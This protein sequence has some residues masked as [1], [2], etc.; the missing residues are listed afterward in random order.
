MPERDDFSDLPGLARFGEALDAAARRAPPVDGGP[1]A[2]LAARRRARARDRARRRGDGGGDGRRA[3]RHGHLR[4]RRPHPAGRPDLAGQHERADRAALRRPRRRTAV[5]AAPDAQPDRPDLH[6]RRPGAR[7]RLRDRRRGPR[8]PPDP[9][10]GRRLVRARPAARQPDR[11]R[12]DDPRDALDRLRRRR[13]HHPAGRADRRGRAAHAVARRA[14]HVRRRAA[15]LSGGHRRP[16]R[17]DGR[18]RPRHRGARSAPGPASC[19]ISPAPPRG[20]CCA[21]SSARASTA[22]G[23][24]TRAARVDRFNSSTDPNGG[25]SS[26]PT[27]CIARRGGFAWAARALRVR[28]R[29]ARSARLRSLA[30]HG[31]RPAHD[32]AR[33]RAGLGPRHAGDGDRRRRAARHSPPPRTGRSRS[34][35]RRPWTRAQLRLSVRL[36]DGTVQRGR[37]G[38]GVVAD[39]VASRRPR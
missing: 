8:V 35:S 39:L 19:P 26:L 21:S 20:A 4:A 30:L 6:D 9:D 14:R 32:P 17:A 36:K 2:P 3:A 31:P 33:R 28:V 1:S 18:R 5:G 27:T 34:S 12:A 22:P 16:G 13:Q 23:W 25:G 15:R 29:A 7:R 37:S 24:A 10:G 38:H 11:R